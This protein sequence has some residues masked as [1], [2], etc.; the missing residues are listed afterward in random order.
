MIYEHFLATEA[1]ET[2]QGLSDL[3][4]LRSQEDGV[5]DFDTR[6]DQALKAS[7]EIHTEMILD[8]LY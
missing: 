2:V 1:Y 6:W 5:Q 8:G 4:N 3:F 7:S